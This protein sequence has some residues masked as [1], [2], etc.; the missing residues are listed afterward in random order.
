MRKRKIWQ[1]QK[2][3]RE[4]AEG[5]AA[6]LGVSPVVVSVLLNRGVREKEEIREFLFGSEQPFHEPLLMK[7]MQKAA[8]RILEAVKNGEQITVYGDYDVDGISASS[9]LYLYLQGLGAKVNTYI[10]KRKNEGYGL[11][12]EALAALAEAGTTLL[13]TVDCGISGVDE[14]AAAPAGLEIIITDHHTPPDVLPAAYAIV[15]PHQRD[16]RY[17]FKYLSGVGVAFKLCQALHQM[18]HLTEPLWSEL[19]ELVALGT[20]ADIVPLRGE[21]R[22]L[23]KLGL[24]AMENTGIVGLQKLIEHSGCPQQNI[25]AENIGFILAPRLN[26]VGRLEHAQSAVE[27]LVTDD[28]AKADMVAEQLN[29]ENA[30]RQEISRKIFIEA[31]AMLAQQERIETAIVLAKEGWHAGVIGIVASRLVDKYHLPTILISI[32]GEAAKGSCRSIPALDLYSALNE[33]SELLLQFGGHHQAAGLTLR[34]ARVESFKKRFLGVVRGRLEPADYQPRLKI[35][36]LLDK[37][38][39]V[40]L[41]LVREL[42]M[43]EPLG[44]DNQ[45]PLFAFKDAVVHYP[46]AFGRDNNHLRFYT[47][48][49]K[50]NYHSIMWNGAADLACLYNNA[51]VDLAFMPKLNVWKDKE[52]VNLQV[53]D[54]D[55]ALQVY[56][57]RNCNV[58]KETV[59]KNILQTSKKTVIYVNNTDFAPRSVSMMPDVQVLAYGEQAEATAENI[60]FYDFPQREI[61]INGALPVPDRS[62]KRLLLLYTRAE[63][64]KL[65]AELEKLYPGRSRLVHAYKELACT[66]RQQAV[67]DRADLLRSAT[68]IS[69]EALKVFEELDFI[70]DEHGKI[71]FGSL[72]K[73]DLQNSPTF[74]GL[75]EEGRAAF[76]SCQRNIQ[77]SPEEI[78]GLWQGNRFNK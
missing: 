69:E 34:A 70:R 52:S 60:I 50:Y 16:C 38:E 26:A 62:G 8:E 54:F 25:S 15:N 64:D 19:T 14:V 72:Q 18:Q 65:C 53:V 77:I 39:E 17:P 9:L 59:L 21:N 29:A 5:I 66:L 32:D 68:D 47:D 1:L 7:D 42:A 27:L 12:N 40:S 71:S 31:E 78:I 37:N 35:E 13:V 51:V 57:Y 44:C 45:P 36:C 55:Q 4:Y 73:N 6:D 24:A 46:K 76:A 43:L 10:P 28:A 3:D 22:A 61:F 33:C 63:A 58:S 2:C 23:V 11:N 49:G 30:L 74:R 67:I 48:Y 41:Q 20:V 75:Q 56:D